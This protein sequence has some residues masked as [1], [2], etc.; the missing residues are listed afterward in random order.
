MQCTQLAFWGGQIP[1][2]ISDL[3][4]KI[5]FPYQRNCI[6][7]GSS[8]SAGLCTLCMMYSDGKIFRIKQW[9]QAFGV[10]VKMVT[11]QEE[12]PVSE[13]NSASDY[14]F[15]PWHAGRRNISWPQ[16]LPPFGWS[17]WLPSLAWPSPCCCR[18]LRKWTSR[19]KTSL[20]VCLW[21]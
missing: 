20:C 9:R 6:S 15:P 4:S 7:F 18:R 3:S 8:F 11:F 14:S 5:T 17:S 13:F 16:S 10:V 1:S 12:V 19:W 21:L 2:S